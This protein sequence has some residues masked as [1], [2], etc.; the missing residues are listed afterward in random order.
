MSTSS[1][2]RYLDSSAAAPKD[3]SLYLHNTPAGKGSEWDTIF[4]AEATFVIK[5]V[6]PV[7]NSFT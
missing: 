6:L 4:I 7:V 3:E 5:V 2:M 1:N